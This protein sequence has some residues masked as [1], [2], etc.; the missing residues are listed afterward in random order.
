M[1]AIL[2]SECLC[3]RLEWH[4]APCSRGGES[5]GAIL[6]SHCRPTRTAQSEC[7]P[8]LRPLMGC[9]ATP[10]VPCPR[11]LGQLNL[12]LNQGLVD[13]SRFTSPSLPQ[14]GHFIPACNGV[15]QV[16]GATYQCGVQSNGTGP[17]S[18]QLQDKV[19]GVAPAGLSL[20][21]AARCRSSN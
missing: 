2:N 15:N 9:P 3:N 20:D 19:G 5:R 13:V 6:H 17:A 14:Y 16:L 12:G 21:R 7:R 4:S 10:L 1:K 11:L 8:R 18:R